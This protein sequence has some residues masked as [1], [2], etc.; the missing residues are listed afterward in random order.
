MRNTKQKKL[1]YDIIY[2]TYDHLD[3]KSI[4]NK[5]KLE[6]P[7]ISLATVYR[8][9]NEL[10][11]LGKVLRITTDNEDHFDRIDT[12]HAHFICSK[13]NKII[14]IFDYTLKY[15]MNDNV[16]YN[17]DLVFHGICS[18]CKKRKENV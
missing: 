14:D 6:M 7:S 3:A 1:V 15:K 18:D 9:L 4:Y 13:C 10:C 17:Y 5:A 12:K 11:N 8:I 2:S 16:V